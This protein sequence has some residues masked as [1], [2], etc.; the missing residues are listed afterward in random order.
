M[1]ID[2]I[3][4]SQ[5]SP[6]IPAPG[7][8][9]AVGLEGQGVEATGSDRLPII[10]GTDAGGDVLVVATAVYQSARLVAAPSSPRPLRLTGHA[11]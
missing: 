2:V 10:V 9:G 1:P 4:V 5:L 6:S 3:T 11:T 7:P 8:E